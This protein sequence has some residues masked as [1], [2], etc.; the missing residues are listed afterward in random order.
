M[1]RDIEV[2]ER[3]TERERERARGGD[4]CRR[5]VMARLETDAHAHTRTHTRTHARAAM[6]VNLT[7][8]PRRE[9]LISSARVTQCCLWNPDNE[10]T[11][12]SSSRAG[13]RA[14]CFSASADARRGE[15]SPAA[16]LSCQPQRHFGTNSLSQRALTDP[17]CDE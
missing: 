16:S 9:P 4:G 14:V 8:G 2:R 12:R 13:A 7:L 10:A 6:R 11:E 17:H 15:T 1:G 5:K 3:Q